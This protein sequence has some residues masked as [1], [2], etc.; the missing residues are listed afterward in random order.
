MFPVALP[1]YVRFGPLNGLRLFRD[2][3]HFPSL[4]RLLH[5][6][7]PTLAVIGGRDPLMP[8]PSR[9]REVGRGAADHVTIALIEQAA[10]AVNF[11]HPKQ[12]AGLV[13]AWLEG[14]TAAGARLP[15]GVHLVDP[16]GGAP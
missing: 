9:V 12:L 8:S 3:T 2:L 6:T 4:D 5:A 14:R 15:D 7:V 11:S 13:E 10:H 16:F 1:D